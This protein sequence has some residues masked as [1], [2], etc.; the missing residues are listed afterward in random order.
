MAVDRSNYGKTTGSGYV[1]LPDRLA[2]AV[3]FKLQSYT[4]TQRNALSLGAGGAGTQ[5]YDS[6]LARVCLWTGAAWK[7]PDGTT[8][9]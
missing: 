2:A 6:T 4:T 8:I 9:S 1:K 7:N 5:V 3:Q